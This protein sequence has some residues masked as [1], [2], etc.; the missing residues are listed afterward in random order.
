MSQIMLLFFKAL[1]ISN[2]KSQ[3]LA[4]S[5]DETQI[6]NRTYLDNKLGVKRSVTLFRGSKKMSTHKSTWYHIM[7]KINQYALSTTNNKIFYK[8]K[9]Q[10]NNTKH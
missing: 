9:G 5:L 2:L 4:L 8:Y 6:N 10:K 7:T 3:T 1:Q